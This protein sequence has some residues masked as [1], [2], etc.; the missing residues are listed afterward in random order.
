M[1]ENTAGAQQHARAAAFAELER[2]TL[3]EHDGGE[4]S[5]VVLGVTEVDGT[6]YALV[7]REEA[8]DRPLY[9]FEYT[10]DPRGAAV[11][12]PIAEDDRYDEILHLFSDVFV[13]E[14]NA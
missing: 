2:V 11:L 7:C 1:R 10:S 5:F 6:D 9:V 14:E 4:V 12:A 13:D 8:T 3:K